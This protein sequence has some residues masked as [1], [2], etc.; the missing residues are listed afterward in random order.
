MLGVPPKSSGGA[1]NRC[2]MSRLTKCAV[3]D[4][5]QTALSQACRARSCRSCGGAGV[6]RLCALCLPPTGQPLVSLRRAQACSPICPDASPCPALLSTARLYGDRSPQRS[7][8]AHRVPWLAPIMLVI[9][10]WGVLLPAALLA[11][12]DFDYRQALVYRALSQAGLGNDI[13]RIWICRSSR[14]RPRP[15][16][17]SRP[18][19][20]VSRSR[21]IRL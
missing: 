15:P 7:P 12:P 10:G 8:G 2:V 13:K 6:Q 20:V 1:T 4:P 16:R 11:E 9:G 19:V 14:Q 17:V 18:G 3:L 21:T 5:F